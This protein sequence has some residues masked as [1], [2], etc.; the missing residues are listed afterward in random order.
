MEL[1]YGDV[2]GFN[3]DEEI[4]KIENTKEKIGIK[5]IPDNKA[6]LFLMGILFAANKR[7]KLLNKK[8][9]DMSGKKTFNIMFSIW[10]NVYN[11][12][13]PNR[14]KTNVVHWFD[15]ILLNEKKNK[16]VFKPILNNE[17]DKKLFLICPVKDANKEQLEKMRKYLKQKRDEGYLTHFPHD[18]TNQVDSLGGYNICKE[19]GNAIGSSSEVHIYYEPSSRGSAF[20]LGMAYYM[21]KSLHIINER[22]FV[23]NMSDYIDKKIYEMSKPKTLIK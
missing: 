4:I 19:N 17:I 16:T 13:F 18:D 12:N 14:K 9:L 3:I 23:Y 11:T 5:V 7:I 22:E 21:K 8:D 6:Q 20:D 10:E 2:Y 15:E 1:K